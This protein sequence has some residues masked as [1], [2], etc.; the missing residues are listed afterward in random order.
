MPP[1][2]CPAPEGEITI[3]DLLPPVTQ[4]PPEPPPPPSR[5]ALRAAAVAAVAAITASIKD[6][7]DCEDCEPCRAAQSGTG[8]VRAYGNTDTAIQGYEYQHHVVNW[9]FHDP[10]GRFIMEWDALGTKWDGLDPTPGTMLN[11]R[12]ISRFEYDPAGASKCY[13]IE[14]KYGYDWWFRYDAY[15]EE[16]VVNASQSRVERLL[17]QFD[18]QVAKVSGVHPNTGL[19][20]ISSS[21]HLEQYVREELVEPKGGGVVASVYYPYTATGRAS[22]G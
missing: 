1:Q 19:V 18:D 21:R 17:N 8:W 2:H 9:F 13:L 20:W 14:A 22:Q 11:S 16:W 15:Q 3:D 5:D 4:P 10:V 7:E 12:A 6:S